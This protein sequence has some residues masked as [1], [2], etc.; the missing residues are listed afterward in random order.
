MLQVQ[1][2]TNLVCSAMGN[3]ESFFLGG[4]NRGYSDILQKDYARFEYRKVNPLNPKL[5]KAA[6]AAI[7]FGWLC[8]ACG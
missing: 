4:Y 6:S 1:D 7:P 5:N 8:Q 3:G 2:F